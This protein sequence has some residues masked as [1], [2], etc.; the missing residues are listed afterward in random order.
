MGATPFYRGLIDQGKIDRY[1]LGHN[2]IIAARSADKIINR[3]ILAVVNGPKAMP[4]R[5]IF[6]KIQLGVLA[7]KPIASGGSP[8]GRLTE[9]VRNLRPHCEGKPAELA[10]LFDAS[11]VSAVRNWR[12][13][14]PVGQ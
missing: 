8:P 12:G 2:G 5:L 6:A 9:V 14:L 11:A 7:H 10:G 1:R 3:M 4:T 13:C